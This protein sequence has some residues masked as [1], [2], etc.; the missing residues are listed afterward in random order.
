MNDASRYWRTPLDAA[1]VPTPHGEVRV[2]TERCKGCGFCVEYC[3]KHVLAL[4]E[5]FN[6]QGYHFPEAVKP[7]ACIDCG[8]CELICPDFAVYN[9]SL[10]DPRVAAVPPAETRR[11]GA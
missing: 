1:T 2:V 10:P 5:A 6:R 9:V 11:T 4:S 8:L 7:E 3:P